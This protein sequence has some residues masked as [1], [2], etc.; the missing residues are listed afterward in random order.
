[1]FESSVRRNGLVKLLTRSHVSRSG[2]SLPPAPP[3]RNPNDEQAEHGSRRH[4]ACPKTGEWSGLNADQ[5]ATEGISKRR[6]NG[7]TIRKRG[8]GMRFTGKT[9]ALTTSPFSG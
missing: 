4:C 2:K 1:M 3:E 6:P 7:L 5:Y 8:A 9:R